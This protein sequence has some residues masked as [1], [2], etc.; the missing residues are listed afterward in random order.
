MNEATDPEDRA[1]GREPAVIHLFAGQGDFTV[2]ALVR[3]CRQGGPLR[4]PAEDVLPEVDRAGAEHGLPP[5]TPWLLGPNPPSTRQLSEAPTGTLQLALYAA[6][7]TV[8]QALAASHGSPA[9]L[10]AVS[11]GEIAALAAAGA[12]SVAEGARIAYDLTR[13]LATCPGGLT[14]LACSERT[15]VAIL[16]SLGTAQVVVAVVN[17]GQETIV[18]GPEAELEAVE[19]YAAGRDVA[20]ARLRLPFSSHHPALGP[21]AEEFAAALRSRTVHPARSPVYSAVAGR[22][23]TQN[24]D[25]PRRLADCLVRP[26]HLPRL[27]HTLTAHRQAN[28]FFEAGTGSALSR[29]VR[30]VLAGRPQVSVHAPL[31]DPAYAW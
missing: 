1:T 10:V 31:A 6:S 27:L 7:L 25:L 23:Y 18:S 17:D 2:S 11:F 24:E 15:A 8:H 14:L 20:A 30:R 5:L 21:Q 12:Y 13:I 28:A 26:A 22:V 29:S 19:K 3:A 4:Q 16:H 9:A